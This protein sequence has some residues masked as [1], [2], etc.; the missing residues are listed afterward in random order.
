VKAALRFT[1]VVKTYGARRALDGLDLEVP[2]GSIFGLVGANGAGKTTFMSVTA[3]LLRA[4]SGVVD[5]LENGPYQPALHRGRLS[6]LPQ[7]SLP[8]YYA[9]VGNLLYYYAR[10]Q[11]LDIRPARRAVDEVLEWVNL[12]DRKHA[13]V[14]SLSH[15]MKRRFTVA[16]AFLGH[17]ELIILDEPMNGLDPAQV[18]S[19]RRLIAS[20]R[21]GQTVIISSHVLPE[22]ETLCDHV[23][24]IDRGRRVRQGTLEEVTHRGRLIRYRLRAAPAVDAL[25]A[26]F[27][28]ATLDWD[29][30]RRLLTAQLPN[31][32]APDQFN[33]AFLPALL[34]QACGIL[35][36]QPGSDLETAYLQAQG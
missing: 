26:A 4:D 6:L 10:L 14:R 22:L 20:R 30:S 7:D 18:A 34:G 35:E 29:D 16:Q 33:Q 19:L 31:G 25:R 1:Q 15:G 2:R 8:P 12:G 9:R 24:F 17:P 11:G 23:A 32:Q 13:P 21:G 36:I 28:D 3:G 5:V 27:A